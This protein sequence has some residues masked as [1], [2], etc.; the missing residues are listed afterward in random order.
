MGLKK[1]S[2]KF[3]GYHKHLITLI[4]VE[5]FSRSEPFMYSK[6]KKLNFPG[7]SQSHRCSIFVVK[8][9]ILFNNY[10]CIKWSFCLRNFP[11]RWLK[12]K[13]CSFEIAPKIME[14]TKLSQVYINNFRKHPFCIIKNNL[15][16]E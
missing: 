8:N 11:G 1:N 4:I 9:I 3:V 15:L 5:Q 2:G 13:S 14:H 7:G 6:A 16:I 10:Y 12:Y